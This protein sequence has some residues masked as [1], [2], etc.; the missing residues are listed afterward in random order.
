MTITD[1][2]LKN[3]WWV[4]HH[5]KTAKREGSQNKPVDKNHAISG[6]NYNNIPKFTPLYTQG[7]EGDRRVV[8]I[9]ERRQTLIPSTIA[10]AKKDTSVNPTP[11]YIGAGCV[12]HYQYWDGGH[13]Q[14]LIPS[15]MAK[16]KNT[17]KNGFPYSLQISIIGP[18]LW[19]VFKARYSIAERLK[20][21]A[22]I[23]KLFVEGAKN[24]IIWEFQLCSSA[25]LILRFAI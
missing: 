3:R 17:H 18:F 5:I 23:K 24:D 6:D 22:P 14:T 20:S 25:R 9:L 4:E 19:R 1:R 2:E 10:G 11:I 7:G 15:I 12:N 16:V 13:R 8:T 21:Y